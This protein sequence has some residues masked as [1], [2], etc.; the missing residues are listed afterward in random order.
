MSANRTINHLTRQT[1]MIIER[2]SKSGSRELCARSSPCSVAKAA[3]L[4]LVSNPILARCAP[5]RGHDRET[6]A[7]L[8]PL[9]GYRKSPAHACPESVADPAQPLSAIRGGGRRGKDY[10]TAGGGLNQAEGSRT[11]SGRGGPLILRN[12]FLELTE[13]SF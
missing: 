5:P 11:L 4:V 10:R 13:N 6:A 7:N 8:R 1:V 2:R 12:L 3:G 9:Q